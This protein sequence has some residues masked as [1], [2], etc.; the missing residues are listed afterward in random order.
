MYD[1]DDGERG[2]TFHLLPMILP[3]LPAT[4]ELE[5]TSFVTIDPAPIIEYSPSVTEPVFWHRLR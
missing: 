5:G 3:G 2:I 4:V 1:G